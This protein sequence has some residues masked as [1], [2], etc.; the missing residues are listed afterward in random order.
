MTLLVIASFFVSP[1]LFTLEELVILNGPSV[2]QEERS[3]LEHQSFVCKI[4]ILLTHVS[5]LLMIKLCRLQEL[6]ASIEVFR[7]LRWISFF[8]LIFMFL[9]RRGYLNECSQNFNLHISY[10]LL[11]YLSVPSAHQVILTLIFSCLNV[12][13][14]ILDAAHV[15][16]FSRLLAEFD[17]HKCEEK[18][19]YSV[20]HACNIPE[21]VPSHLISARLGEILCLLWPQLRFMR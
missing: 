1:G 19:D 7:V 6:L 3:F 18:Q 2:I 5:K 10:E 14:F 20:C 15:S 8:I 17:G 16:S 9:D 21:R 13:W 12:I 4:F 11:S